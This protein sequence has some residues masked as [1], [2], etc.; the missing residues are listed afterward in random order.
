MSHTPE[1]ELMREYVQKKKMVE[2]S[3]A[4]S[5]VEEKKQMQVLEKLQL[6]YAKLLALRQRKLAVS[7][8]LRI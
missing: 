8:T 1:F 6:Q 4:S 3:M 2:R 7:P 5:V